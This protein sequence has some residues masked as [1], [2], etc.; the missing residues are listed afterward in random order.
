M[1]AR[2]NIVPTTEI[3]IAATVIDPFPCYSLLLSFFLFF[4]FLLLSF[5]PFYYENAEMRPT[6]SEDYSTRR[7]KAL[8][9]LD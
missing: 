8:I 5:S 2:R 3:S 1:T 6:K 9:G 4:F 7:V